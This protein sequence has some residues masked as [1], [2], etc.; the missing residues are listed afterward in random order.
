MSCLVLSVCYLTSWEDVLVHHAVPDP[1]AL[2]ALKL[3]YV[4]MYVC[5]QAG[6]R[7]P[8]PR[9]C[10]LLTMPRWPGP[11]CRACPLRSILLGEAGR[12]SN[13]SLYLSACSE[14]ILIAPDRIGSDRINHLAGSA[15]STGAAATA[16]QISGSGQVCRRG[17]HVIIHSEV[18]VVP[19]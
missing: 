6:E 10:K 3:S 12:S 7:A 14:R 18:V 13:F 16:K 8:P 1:L 5:R 2:S 9:P 17:I 19:V 4:C 15:D 11:S